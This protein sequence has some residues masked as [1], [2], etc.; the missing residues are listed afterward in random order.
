[1]KKKSFVF[2][3]A[4]LAVCAIWMTAAFAVEEGAWLWPSSYGYTD[5]IWI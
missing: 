1:M 2:L 3:C 4:C 5:T